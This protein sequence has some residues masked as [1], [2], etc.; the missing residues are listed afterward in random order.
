MLYRIP[1]F[2]CL[3]VCQNTCVLM[4]DGSRNNEKPLDVSSSESRK[5]FAFREGALTLRMM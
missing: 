2:L 5:V 3:E 4:Q 1:G